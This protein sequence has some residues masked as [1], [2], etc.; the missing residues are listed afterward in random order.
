MSNNYYFGRLKKKVLACQRASE[1]LLED[2]RENA[3]E[4]KNHELPFKFARTEEVVFV[5]N[6][7]NSV[8]CNSEINFQASCSINNNADK[9]QDYIEPVCS[10]AESDSDSDL[11]YICEKNESVN[12]SNE[13]SIVL[14]VGSNN[15]SETL[16]LSEKL[17][18]WAVKE[19]ISQS[20]L[21]KLL[22]ILKSENDILSFKNL[23]KDSRTLLHTPVGKV[24]VVKLG[25]GLFY[26]FGILN[27]INKLITK[28]NYKLSDNACFELAVNVDGLSIS[29]STSSCFWPILAQIKSIDELKDDVI[30]VALFFGT[31]KPEN[32]NE[33]LKEFVK[34]SVLL[35]NNGILVHNKFYKF[36]ISMLICDM[37]AKSFLLCTKGHNAYFSGT[38]YK[39]EGDFVNNVV[40]FPEYENIKQRSDIEFREQVDE[41]YHLGETVLTKLPDFDMVRNVPLDYMHL[42]CLGVVKRLLVH[43]TYGWVFARQPFKFSYSNIKKISDLLSSLNKF[44]PSE[45]CTKTRSIEECKRYKATEFRL[46]L[47]YVGS[48]VFKSSLNP[49]FYSNF[50]NLHVASL[51]MCRQEYHK[52]AQMLSYA[53]DLMKYFVKKTCEMY[54][55]DFVSHNVHNLVHLAGDVSLNGKLDNFSAFPFENYMSQLKKNA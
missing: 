42:L 53:N 35:V 34:E 23:P 4:K 13:N 48:V 44:I 10:N 54:G 33:F 43:K 15:L 11:S 7:I 28:S 51:I 25:F 3:Q 20:S 32:S 19:N 45:F 40:C 5:E 14:P 49:Q 36:K 50:L 26:Y 12:T 21:N 6:V 16:N 18:S 27:S 9:F 22:E 47:L 39:T 37:P 38:K 52:D 2:A 41:E 55:H 17:T 1:M 8:P 29:T 30:V 24:E 46:F 31:L